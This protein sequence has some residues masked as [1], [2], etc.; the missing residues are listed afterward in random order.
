MRFIWQWNQKI[1]LYA[2]IIL[3]RAGKIKSNQGM[4]NISGIIAYQLPPTPVA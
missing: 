1:E 2:D 3:H 4:I